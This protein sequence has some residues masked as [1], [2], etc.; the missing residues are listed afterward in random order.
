[1]ATM[2]MSS[3]C[4]LLL[5]TNI[6]LTKGVPGE[7]LKVPTSEGVRTLQHQQ[8]ACAALRNGE[9][10]GRK[11]TRF[12]TCINGDVTVKECP[13]SLRF[14]T[15]TKKCTNPELATCQLTQLDISK[16]SPLNCKLPK[17][18][19]YG[20]RPDIPVRDTPQFVMVTFDDSVTTLK[21]ESYFKDIFVDN[22]HQIFN[23]SG[24]PLRAAFFVTMVKATNTSSVLRLWEAGHEIASHTVHHRL[25]E[26]VNAIDYAEMASECIHNPGADPA[27]ILTVFQSRF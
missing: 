1:M 3:L 9:N 8:T 10:I 4:L 18:S 19:C 2:V 21:Y 20:S 13:L 27:Q 24:C 6:K 5:M 26:G 11:G 22:V 15:V 12:I 25:P 14:D 16:C 17:C 7:C 23:P